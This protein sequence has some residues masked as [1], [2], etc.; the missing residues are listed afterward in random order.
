MKRLFALILIVAVVAALC[1]CSRVRISED[2]PVT[3]VFRCGDTSVEEP[4]TDAE[5]AQ[6][7]EIFEGKALSFDNP[8]CGFTADVSLRV[9]GHIFCPACDQC[10]IVMD[11]TSLRYFSLTQAERDVI[12]SIFAAHGGYFPCI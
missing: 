12:E 6:V 11:L 4:L 5:A 1:G 10:R 7:I 3:L 8:S 2:R 9:G